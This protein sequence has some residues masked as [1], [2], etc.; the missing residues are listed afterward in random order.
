VDPVKGMSIAI[1]WWKINVNNLVT[2]LSPSL[3]VN[4]A[5]AGNPA[6]TGLV[7]RNSAGE[8]TSIVGTNVNA[9]S[10]K[11]QGIDIDAR[12]AFLKSPTYGNFALRLNGTY[13][14][15][16]D[17]TL[18]DGTVQPSVAA[19]ID[20]QGNVLNA[21][22]AGIIFRWKDTLSLD[23]KRKEWSASLINNFQSGYWDNY[24]ADA[25][26]PIAQHVGAFSTWD[27]QAS[28]GGIKNL[29]L[30]AGVKNL[31]NRKPP[32]VITAGSYFQTGYD[33]SY[34]DPHGQTGY[35]SANY[36]F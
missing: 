16:Y 9:G 7:T 35:L 21:A 23:W 6:Y 33:P 28:Y 2:T 36:K 29:T 10:V 3:V 12:Y 30:T 31:F 4:Q 19:T 17:M 14:S 13:T 27:L 1:D 34:F 5:A 8:I 25:V 22:T 11:T 32:E 18:P 20:G 15:K 26:D 24:R